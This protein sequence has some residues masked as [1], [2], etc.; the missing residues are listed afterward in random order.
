LHLVAEANHRKLLVVRMYANGRH[1]VLARGNLKQAFLLGHVPQAKPPVAAARSERRA[2]GRQHHR[3]NPI[4]VPFQ[5][6]FELAGRAVPDQDAVIVR[7]RRNRPA[8]ARDSDTGNDRRSLVVDI[9]AM[10]HSRRTDF[11]R[12]RRS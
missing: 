1:L 3:M 8:V 2:I 4:V 5:M 7:R 6:C 11:S 9:D 10:N 12:V